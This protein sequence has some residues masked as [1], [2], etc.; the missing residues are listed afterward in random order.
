MDSNECAR[1]TKQWEFLL[2]RSQNIAAG[3][4]GAK[5]CELAVGA[6]WHQKL[7]DGEGGRGT[8]E[9]SSQPQMP[10]SG[11]PH[12]GFG[13]KMAYFMKL[14]AHGFCL[15]SGQWVS[16]IHSSPPSHF[17]DYKLK[18]THLAFSVGSGDWTW[19]LLFVQQH[20]SDWAIF[21]AMQVVMAAQTC[22]SSTQKVEAGEAG[23]R[24]CCSVGPCCLVRGNCS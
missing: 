20:F 15:A 5:V 19:V 2:P 10:L 8:A 11:A 21:P 1:D 17:R 18:P 3:S 9:T 24:E 4:V 6:D 23:G 13:N 7:M 22:A 16:G 14:V 12:L